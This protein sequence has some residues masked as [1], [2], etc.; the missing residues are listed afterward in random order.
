VLQNI[1]LRAIDATFDRG[2]VRSLLDLGGV[3]AVDGG[4]TFHALER[5]QP[6]RVVLVDEEVSDETLK[7]A[8]SFPQL[9]IVQGNFGDP[10]V[11]DRIGKVDAAILFDVLLHQVAPDWD[12]VMRLYAEHARY[13]IIV[14]PQYVLGDETVRLLD[15]GRERYL[16]LV[17]DVPE[18]HAVWERMDEYVPELGRQFRDIHK[19]WQWGITDADLKRHADE[20]GL[21]LVFFENGGMWQD[22]EAFETHAFAFRPR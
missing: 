13:L 5:H 3:W 1:K 17:P 16:E 4:Y 19:L 7:R 18:H 15:L 11:A 12:N 14:Q 8:R 22:R 9:E 21:E 20:L 10:A 6:E 2:D